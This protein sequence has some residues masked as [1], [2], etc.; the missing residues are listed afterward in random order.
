M[1][2][3][4]DKDKLMGLNKTP[5]NVPEGYF[6]AFKAGMK[7]QAKKFSPAPYLS[8]AAMFAVI[9]L[10]GT[11]ILKST[12]KAPSED[13]YT[14]FYYCDLL[15]TVEDELFVADHYSRNETSPETGTYNEDI[16]EDNLINYLIYTG[17]SIESIGQE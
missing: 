4:T 5:F 3:L 15:P 14:T 1:G 7:P 9:A 8:L 6:E 13:I 10:T 17:T 2:T 11:I 16:S 12:Q